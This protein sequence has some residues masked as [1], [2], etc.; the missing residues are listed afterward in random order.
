MHKLKAATKTEKRGFMETPR[1]AL[2]DYSAVN[3]LDSY[4]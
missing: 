3:K 2:A 1:P 4:P